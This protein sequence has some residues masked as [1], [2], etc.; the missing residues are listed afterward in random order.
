MGAD[1]AVVLAVVV[2]GALGAVAGWN[3]GYNRGQAEAWTTRE[4]FDP[5]PERIPDDPD[6]VVV[7]FRR[8]A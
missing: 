6:G 4:G 3:L 2:A 1:L 8:I 5:D 7:P